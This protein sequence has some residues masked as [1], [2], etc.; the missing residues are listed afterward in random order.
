MLSVAD[1]CPD[2]SDGEQVFEGTLG[3]AGS[4]EVTVRSATANGTAVAARTASRCRGC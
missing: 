3:I 1:S 2:Q 4:G